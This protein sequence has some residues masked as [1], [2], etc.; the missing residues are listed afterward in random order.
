MKAAE[1]LFDMDF[2]IIDNL[3]LCQQGFVMY[4]SRN[5]QGG[6]PS[7]DVVAIMQDGEWI[8]VETNNGDTLLHKA[9]KGVTKE[10]ELILLQDEVSIRT[11]AECHPQLLPAAS[12]KNITNN[13]EKYY[14]VLCQLK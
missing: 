6:K 7:S 14:I 4:I 11:F 12:L 9:V 2:A 13:E 10:D 8:C 5:V 3:F 1:M